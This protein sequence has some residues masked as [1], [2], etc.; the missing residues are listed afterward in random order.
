MSDVITEHNLFKPKH[1]KTESKAD[2]TTHIARALI[3]AEVELRN[4]KTARLR[5]ARLENEATRA[6]A[7]SAEEPR[8]AIAR[9]RPGA[10]I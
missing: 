1:S 3:G 2:A 6:S 10:S 7:S 5:E 4:A 8:R 9:R